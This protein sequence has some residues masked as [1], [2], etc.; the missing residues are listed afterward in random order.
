MSEASIRKF[1]AL[2]GNDGVPIYDLFWS[3]YLRS[4]IYHGKGAD[5]VAEITAWYDDIKVLNLQSHPVSLWNG[6]MKSGECTV[7]LCGP[8]GK[9]ILREKKTKHT[10]SELKKLSGSLVRKIFAT[11]S[12]IRLYG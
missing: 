8:F 1:L 4:N 2:V 5:Q 11:D 10:S 9:L 7:D 12:R 6:F 3:H